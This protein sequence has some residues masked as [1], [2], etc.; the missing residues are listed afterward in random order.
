MPVAREQIF[1]TRGPVQRYR[2]L[3][4][5]AGDPAKSPQ[6]WRVG[7]PA[8]QLVHRRLVIGPGVSAGSVKKP[9]TE[10]IADAAPCRAENEHRLTIRLRAERGRGKQRH[11]SNRDSVMIREA[12]CRH[13]DHGTG[14]ETVCKHVIIAGLHSCE[15]ASS[16]L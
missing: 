16:I 13:I 7:W 8:A 9:V 3:N 2:K 6:K 12:R 14:D 4:A 11:P 15:E 1:Q 5:G 10:G